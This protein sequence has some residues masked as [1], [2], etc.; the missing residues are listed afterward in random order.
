MN[1]IKDAQMVVLFVFVAMLTVI[2]HYHDRMPVPNVYVF[3]M[4]IYGVAAVVA[5]V[6]VALFTIA[7]LWKRFGWPM[8]EMVN[9]VVYAACGKALGEIIALLSQRPLSLPQPY[10]V[11]LIGLVVLV[12]YVAAKTFGGGRYVSSYIVVATAY[13][14]YCD[15]VLLGVWG[16]KHGQG[17]RFFANSYPE[18]SVVYSAECVLL[19]MGILLL[20]DDIAMIVQLSVIGM[21]MCVSSG[22][23]FIAAVATYYGGNYIP[24]NPPKMYITVIILVVYALAYAFELLLALIRE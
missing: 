16:I 9:L 5:L 1:K 19:L 8:G 20:S 7:L 14:L 18:A 17:L 4:Y 11:A 3:G 15:Y 22:I 10:A 6:I 23:L 21:L 12:G 13:C 2:G 24:Y